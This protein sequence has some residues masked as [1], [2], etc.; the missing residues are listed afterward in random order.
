[1]IKIWYIDKANEVLRKNIISK[2]S[3]YIPEVVFVCVPN[4]ESTRTNS[5]IVL[6]TK[7]YT[8]KCLPELIANNAYKVYEL[9]LDEILEYGIFVE[10]LILNLLTS[11]I[12]EQVIYEFIEKLRENEDLIKRDMHG[13]RI[14]NLEEMSDCLDGLEETIQMCIYKLGMDQCDTEDML[15]DIIC[16]FIETGLC[17]VQSLED[18]EY[19]GMQSVYESF[20]CEVEMYLS[21]II[22]DIYQDIIQNKKL[23]LKSVNYEII[24]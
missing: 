19:D 4:L 11:Q 9:I 6:V 1:M 15:E 17:V 12:T 7:D 21:D 23:Y 18:S 5:E 3:E 13:I 20:I 16:S 14:E 2:I 22:D 8:D 10:I 24:L